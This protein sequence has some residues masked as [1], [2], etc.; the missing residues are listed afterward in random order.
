MPI[1]TSSRARLVLALGLLLALGCSG[2][3]SKAVYPVQ[4]QAFKGSQP[5]VGAIIALH[6]LGGEDKEDR[7]RPNGTVADDGSFQLTTYRPNDG[8]PEGE[9]AVTVIWLDKP[10]GSELIGGGESRGTPADR[11]KGAYATPATTKLRATVKSGST[12]PVRV[13]VP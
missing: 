4:G 7:T 6:P 2:G 13:E 11:L 3:G 10:R 8:A 5:L 12:N 9:Y 1:S